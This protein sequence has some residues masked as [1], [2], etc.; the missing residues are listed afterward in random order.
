MY[1][2]ASQGILEAFVSG[3]IDETG[4]TTVIRVCS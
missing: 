2:V 3:E 4:N 1:S